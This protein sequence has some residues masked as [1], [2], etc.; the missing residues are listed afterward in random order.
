MLSALVLLLTALGT[1]L[2]L[3]RAQLKNNHFAESQKTCIFLKV[4]GFRFP[5]GGVEGAVFSHLIS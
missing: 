2:Q 4:P 5:L 3:L 1:V